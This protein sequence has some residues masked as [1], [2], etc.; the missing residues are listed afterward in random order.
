MSQPDISASSG[1]KRH[2]WGVRVFPT[3]ATPTSPTDLGKAETSSLVPFHG[4]E[5]A[6]FPK[7][8][9]RD[10]REQR[11]PSRW[12]WLKTWNNGRGQGKKG[13][14]GLCKLHRFVVSSVRGRE[15]LWGC[16]YSG[17]FPLVCVAWLASR[18]G[19][20]SRC[21]GDFFFGY[22]V[23]SWSRRKRHQHHY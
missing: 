17:R 13:K 3:W 20:D 4:W 18:A 16:G 21:C 15:R 6:D 14:W 8:G 11:G 9:K 7:M 5:R 19:R 22:A 1:T 2:E 10:K 12:A 23:S